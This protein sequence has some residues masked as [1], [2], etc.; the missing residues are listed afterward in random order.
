MPGGSLTSRN[1]NPGLSANAGTV[2]VLGNTGTTGPGM[3]SLNSCGMWATDAHCMFGTCAGSCVTCTGG[4]ELGGSADG[5]GSALTLDNGCSLVF[6]TAGSDTAA[7]PKHKTLHGA[8]KHPDAAYRDMSGCG[9]GGAKLCGADVGND[10]D[11]LAL[12]LQGSLRVRGSLRLVSGSGA[13]S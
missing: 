5:T 6:A 13:P 10:Q 2:G 8:L 4:C 1:P 12:A 9:A 3:R 7:R 11:W